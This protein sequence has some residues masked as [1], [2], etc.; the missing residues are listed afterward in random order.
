[1]CRSSAV[2]EREP[3]AGVP[4]RDP[5]AAS[6]PPITCKTTCCTEGTRTQREHITRKAVTVLLRGETNA[7]GFRGEMDVIS[8][9]TQ[10]CWYSIIMSLCKTNDTR[11]HRH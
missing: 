11:T 5:A 3:A 4:Y 7:A 9:V 8:T 2:R 6:H 10:F 1:M